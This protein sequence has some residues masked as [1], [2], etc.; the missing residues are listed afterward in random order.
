MLSNFTAMLMQ[1]A[2][3]CSAAVPV[4]QVDSG[5]AAKSDVG[6]TLPAVNLTKC[7]ILHHFEVC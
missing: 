1:H 6:E 4:A 7:Y 2:I 5:F 3:A